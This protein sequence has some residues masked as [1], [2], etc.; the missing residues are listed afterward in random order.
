MKLLANSRRRH[1][2]SP[3]AIKTWPHKPKTHGN[4]QIAIERVSIL[5]SSQTE[6]EECVYREQSIT[7]WNAKPLGNFF[8]ICNQ[9]TCFLLKLIDLSLCGF[10]ITTRNSLSSSRHVETIIK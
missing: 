6:L 7:D 2:C 10:N 5:T 1:P 8:H 9:D 3:P 4:T